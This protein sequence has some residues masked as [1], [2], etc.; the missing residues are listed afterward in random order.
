MKSRMIAES[1]SWKNIAQDYFKIY[2]E[3]IN[4]GDQHENK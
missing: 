3:L 2:K 1:M 4:K